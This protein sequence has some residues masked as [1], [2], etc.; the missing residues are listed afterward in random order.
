MPAPHSSDDSNGIF[1]KA[2]QNSILKYPPQQ[3]SLRFITRIYMQHVILWLL[4]HFDEDFIRKIYFYFMC[5]RFYLSVCLFVCVSHMCPEVV[6]RDSECEWQPFVV[7]S[8]GRDISLSETLVKREGQ[9][10]APQ[11]L[12]ARRFSPQPLTP[13]SLLVNRTI[14]I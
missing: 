5:M 1:G 11:P 8:E 2:T 12:R 10:A 7:W 9:L 3:I 13:Q 6:G 4:K 14:K